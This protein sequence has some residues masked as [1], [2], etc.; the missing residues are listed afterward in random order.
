MT[1]RTISADVLVIG[2]G[3]VGCAILREL[4]RYD[5]SVALVEGRPDIGDA[6][7]KANSAIVHTGFDAP[8]GTL[9]AR[10]LAEA[11]DMWPQV[12]EQLRIPY[13]QTGALMVATNGKEHAALTDEIIP[14][15]R[16]NGVT[17]QPLTRAEL[18]DR[19]PYLTSEAV[20]GVLVEGE[21]VIDPF[22]TTCAYCENAVR[23]GAAVY[24]G[25]AITAMT[26]ESRGL[27]ARTSDGATFTA[28]VV[29]NAAGLWADEV[30]RLAGDDSFHL[31]PRKGQFILTKEDHGV[32]QV[33][34]PVPSKISKGI[35]VAP[36]VFGGV[37][38][39]P[40]TTRAAA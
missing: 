15:A 16:H 30:A 40:T 20:G 8:P 17:V 31:T 4:S 36:A 34:L 38:L 32:A 24:L 21:G 6:T 19:A 28:Q 12:L 2:G 9:E 22:W 39:G 3:V 13:L 14:R 18:L 7:S 27:T 25:H 10:L 35:L 23:N 33:I 37:L 5:A 26:V 29:V 1:A 11:R